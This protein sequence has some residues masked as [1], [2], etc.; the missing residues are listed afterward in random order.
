MIFLK[1]NVLLERDLQLQ[2]VK[3]RLLG[4]HLVILND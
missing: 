4:K 3:P 1:D 2:D